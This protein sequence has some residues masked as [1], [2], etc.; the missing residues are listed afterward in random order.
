MLVAVLEHAAAVLAVVG[1]DAS[2]RMFSSVCGT[3]RRYFAAS[4]VVRNLDRREF[5]KAPAPAF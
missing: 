1:A 5:G 4:T 3:S 2:E